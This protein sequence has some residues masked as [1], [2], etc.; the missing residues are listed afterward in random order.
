MRQNITGESIF[1]MELAGAQLALLAYVAKLLGGLQDAHDVL[2]NVN[3]TLCRQ[4]DRYDASRPFQA[5]ART[6]A[7]YEVMTWRK[8]QVR[9]RLVFS[10][11]TVERLAES[12]SNA[13]DPVDQ[14]LSFLDVC[15]KKLPA[16]MRELL[17]S[18]YGREECLSDI[19]SRMRRTE[20]SVA[21][22]LYYIRKLLKGCV[23]DKLAQA[24]R[25]Y[26]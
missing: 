8:R 18:Y 11:E 19:A 22:S 24:E 13:P 2:Q 20:G 10:D 7:Y 17:E 16:L 4:R 12:L 6:V 15:K 26:E 5:W 23:E 25:R 14:K 9:S 3:L 1:E 21:N